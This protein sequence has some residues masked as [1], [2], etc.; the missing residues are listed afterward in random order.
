MFRYK[1]YKVQEVFEKISNTLMGS[2]YVNKGL[3]FVD[4]TNKQFARSTTKT[5]VWNDSGEALSSK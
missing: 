5:V 3:Q 1:I 2:D 4:R